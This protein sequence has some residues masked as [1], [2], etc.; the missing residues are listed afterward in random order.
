MKRQLKP[1]NRAFYRRAAKV[2]ARDLLG[3]WILRRMGDDD[4]VVRIVET[5]AYLG[6]PDRAS[7]AWNGR[8]TKRTSTLYSPGGCAYVYLVYGLHHCLNAVTGKVGEG[9]AVLIR[10]G[11]P[12]CGEGF[13]LANRNLKGVI[14]PGAIGGGPGKLCQAL[15][16]D[17]SHNG[18]SLAKGELLITAGEPVPKGEIVCGPRVGIDYA[19]EAIDW[20]LRFAIRGNRHM[21]RPHL[22]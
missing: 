21:S 11:E 2:V 12:V 14:K 19:Q 17:R 6:A 20:P 4:L 3:R 1:L 15:A 7:H 22:S 9:G 10:A 5:E 8:Q 18:V 16:I 13:M